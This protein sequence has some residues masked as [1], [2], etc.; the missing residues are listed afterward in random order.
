MEDAMN[1]WKGPTA[2]L[3]IALAIAAA[4]LPAPFEALAYAPRSA[5]TAAEEPFSPLFSRR[6]E[7]GVRNMDKPA[8]RSYVARL[9]VQ[10]RP[11]GTPL[12]GNPLSVCIGSGCLGSVCLGSACLSSRCLGSACIASGCGGSTC[13]A[14]GCGGSA[15]IGSGCGGSACVGTVCAGSACSAGCD[16][17]AP[18]GERPLG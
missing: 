4:F 5:P 16:A 12:S 10:T 17:T 8:E 1:A 13:I 14:S 2:R 11:L 7:V 15:C 9:E 3:A 18:P 6:L